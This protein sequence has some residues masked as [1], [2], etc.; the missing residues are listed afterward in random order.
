MPKRPSRAIGSAL[1]KQHVEIGGRTLSQVPRMGGKKSVGATAPLL[2]EHA[3]ELPFD[4]ELR[5]SAERNQFVGPD[6]V[7]SHPGPARTF[8]MTWIGHL[9]QQR[10]H[11]QFLHKRRVEG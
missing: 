11:A 8:A 6:P 9:L 3:D 10:D 1:L 2:L 7:G 4:I 5:G